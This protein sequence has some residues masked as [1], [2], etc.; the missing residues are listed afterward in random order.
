MTLLRL[1]RTKEWQEIYWVK[2]ILQNCILFFSIWK[3]LLMM[4]SVTIS[5]VTHERFPIYFLFKERKLR[6]ANNKIQYISLNF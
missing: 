6:V 2:E 5:S 1:L 3:N 4:H